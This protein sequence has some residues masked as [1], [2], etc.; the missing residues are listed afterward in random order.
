MMQTVKIPSDNT[1]VGVAKDRESH[2]TLTCLTLISCTSLVTFC[3]TLSL[4]V[5]YAVL[6]RSSNKAK[7]LFKAANTQSQYLS[8]AGTG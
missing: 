6:T 1:L 7:K 4:S 5:S 8:L 3:G 2:P